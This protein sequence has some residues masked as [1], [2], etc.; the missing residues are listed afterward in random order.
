MLRH[1]TNEMQAPVLPLTA[2]PIVTQTPP[3]L[4]EADRH[5]IEDYLDQVMS[6]LTTVLPFA[7]RQELRRE[8]RQHLEAIIAAHQ[9]LGEDPTVACDKAFAQFGKPT[10]I[11]ESIKRSLPIGRWQRIRTWW[12]QPRLS[13]VSTVV[14][15]LTLVGLVY[16]GIGSR[17][18]T[19]QQPPRV[20]TRFATTSG[21]TLVAAAG[22]SHRVAIQTHACTD[23]HRPPSRP[24]PELRVFWQVP[25]QGEVPR[26][27]VI[28]QVPTQGE[29]SPPA[30]T[31]K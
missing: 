12:T 7:R 5:R 22:F 29:V 17:P 25:R 3:A 26:G 15:L 11:A 19:Q 10:E 16:L 2:E 27:K 8:V 30:A 20:Q 24:F 13:V 9:E 31:A 1:Q 23:C 6:P 4:L 28:W 18:I 14:P 21:G